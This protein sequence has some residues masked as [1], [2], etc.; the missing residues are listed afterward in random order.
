VPPLFACF[1][2]LLPPQPRLP[3]SSIVFFFPLFALFLSHPPPHPQLPHVFSR[4][5]LY[6][7]SA[8]FPP[9]SPFGPDSSALWVASNCTPTPP[10]PSPRAPMPRSQP[11]TSSLLSFPLSHR[12]SLSLQTLPILLPPTSLQLFPRLATHLPFL[13]IPLSLP[14]IPDDP[15][16]IS[17]FSNAQWR[18]SLI[19]MFFRFPH[20]P[21]FCVFLGLPWEPIIPPLFM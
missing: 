10:L 14:Y 13:F 1:F 20:S 5:V 19:F 11:L 7:R 12:P 21:F 4:V 18:T 15:L 3:P 17:V 2:R 16:Q 6:L 9:L 8:S